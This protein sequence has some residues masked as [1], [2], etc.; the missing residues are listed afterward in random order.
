MMRTTV[1]TPTIGFTT[2]CLTR[3][4]V[5]MSTVFIVAMSTVPIIVLFGTFMI[6]LT[7]ISRDPTIIQG[8][9]ITAMAGAIKPVSDWGSLAPRSGEPLRSYAA[10]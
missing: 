2:D 6:R 9:A 1:T 5:P 3:T 4:D 8:L 10:V 7:D